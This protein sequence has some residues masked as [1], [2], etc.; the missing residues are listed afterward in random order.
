MAKPTIIGHR[1]AMAY[2]PENTLASFQK[3]IEL[4]S[5]MIELDVHLTKDKQVVVIH[6]M[7]VDRTTDGKGKV[8][9]LTLEEIKKFTIK[10]TNAKIPIL[11]EVIDL[12]NFRCQINIEVK[13]EKALEESIKVVEKNGIENITLISS[14]I[15]DVIRKSKELNPKIKRALLFVTADQE[16]LELAKELGVY[17]LHVHYNTVSKE[18]LE[19]AHNFGFRVHAW[20]VEDEESIQK[21]TSEG[22]DGIIM[23]DPGMLK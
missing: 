12:V 8:N 16:H 21:I 14:F 19:K 3:A 23:N 13:D 9:N 17:S 18:L 20:G 22:V 2:K 1:G 6:D 11:Q 4:G 5:D 7:T 10:D 15:Q